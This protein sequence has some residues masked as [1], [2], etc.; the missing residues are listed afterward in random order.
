[1]F[2]SML[3]GLTGRKRVNMEGMV[4]Q[5]AFGRGAFVNLKRT[6]AALTAL[7]LVT[8]GAATSLAAAHIADPPHVLRAC[9]A[10]REGDT[11]HLLFRGTCPKGQ[12]EIR[13][14][15]VGP[16]GPRGLRGAPGV[17]EI[18]RAHV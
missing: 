10:P 7:A 15:V 8:G 16:E 3:H 9:V 11:L 13:W 17:R 14:N 4:D 12:S 2:D 1:M 18:G 6:T 5:R